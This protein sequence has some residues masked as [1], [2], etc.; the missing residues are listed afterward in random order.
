LGQSNDSS[1]SND[2]ITPNDASLTLN[3]AST[4]LCPPQ[5]LIEQNNAENVLIN[6]ES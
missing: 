4:H 6:P 3:I 1:S 2:E 5:L